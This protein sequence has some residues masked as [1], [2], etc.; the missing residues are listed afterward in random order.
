MVIVGA[1]FGGLAAARKLGSRPVRVTVYDRMNYHLF[2]PLL[3]Q[4]AL[5]SLNGTDV[6]IPIRS[7]LRRHR[8]VAVG[9]GEVTEVDTRSR[10]VLLSDGSKKTYDYLILAAGAQTNYYGHDEWAS[11]APGLKNLD[12][13]L[14]IRRRVLMAFEAAERAETEEERARLLT[15]I[16][17]GGGAT[18]VELAG[19]IKDLSRDI[20]SQE[21]RNVSAEMT[22]VILLEMTDRILPPFAPELSES[23]ARQ[24]RGLGVEVRTGAHVS[25]IDGL[26]VWLGEELIPGATVLWG[27]GVTPSSLGR[28]LGAPLDRGGR[29]L[30]R[31]DCSVPEHP[32]VFVIGDMAAF[33]P[34]GQARPLPGVSPVAIQEGQSVARNI[35]S[36]LRAGERRAFVYRDKGL[37]ATIG[38]ARAVAQIGRFSL[39]G[40][41]AWLAWAV[42]HLWY[43]VGF[44][45]RLL[46]F[47]NWIWAYVMS[48][49]GARIIVGP[50]IVQKKDIHAEPERR[51]LTPNS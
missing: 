42:V 36:D 29:V 16:L 43:L 30:V 46:V 47:V 17:I 22:R 7:V 35:L 34:E 39:S 37:M 20:L 19:A 45:N 28:S 15:F 21:F 14:E 3:Y 8:N 11:I 38:R 18:G 6:A 40:T 10:S 41:T 12:D 24:L 2:Q 48:K 31:Q 50:S 32:E 33:V 49:H 13:A 25:C 27:A 9:L 44:R 1:G 23:A 4:V 5:A 26:G 51:C